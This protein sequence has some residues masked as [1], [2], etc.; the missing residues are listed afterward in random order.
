M[1]IKIY[2]SAYNIFTGEKPTNAMRS[3]NTKDALADYKWIQDSGKNKVITITCNSKQI[4]YSE[5]KI[6]DLLEV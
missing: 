1:E 2:V 5:L 6:M 3:S 4:S